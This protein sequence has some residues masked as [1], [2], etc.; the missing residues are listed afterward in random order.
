MDTP[1]D[2]GNEFSFLM[3]GERGAGTA[4]PQAEG[5]LPGANDVAAAKEQHSRAAAHEV[6]MTPHIRHSM[7]GRESRGAVLEGQFDDCADT[8]GARKQP[9][10]T[11]PHEVL[12]SPGVRCSV[13][14]ADDSLSRGGRRTEKQGQGPSSGV[15]G[16]DL[17]RLS[18]GDPLLHGGVDPTSRRSLGRGTQLSEAPATT[19]SRSRMDESS[20]GRRER[21]AY[22][23]LGPGLVADGGLTTAVSK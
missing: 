6:L 8:G 17:P 13:S 12:V 2:E 1:A 22:E 10:S 5:K 9:I 15:G 16:P 4:P 14:A 18:L 3:E 7:Y 19:S 11:A 20:W 23:P 21:Q